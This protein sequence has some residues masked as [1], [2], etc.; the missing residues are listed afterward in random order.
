MR[1]FTQQVS[2]G[3]WGSYSEAGLLATVSCQSTC[4]T[5]I[6][7]LK[8]GRR[9]VPKGALNSLYQVPK[10]QKYAQAS[11]AVASSDS[12]RSSRPPVS[13]RKTR[14]VKVS[15][16][17]AAVASQSV[18]KTAV[19]VAPVAKESAQKL[20]ALM[21]LR[22][23]QITVASAAGASAQVVSVGSVERA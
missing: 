16:A 7:N 20:S 3:K 14:R 4:D 11:S 5:I 17:N 6:A 13:A 1:F 12:R 2:P 21:D 22:K 18:A 8:S 23:Q 15:A 10:L 19:Q 9:D